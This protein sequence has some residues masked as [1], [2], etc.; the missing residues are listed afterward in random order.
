M[1][2]LTLYFGCPLEFIT[3]WLIVHSY[4]LIF[5]RLF[6]NSPNVSI[7]ASYFLQS[8][9]YSAN[10]TPTST[11]GLTT[12]STAAGNKTSIFLALDCPLVLLLFESHAQ[13]STN[14]NEVKIFAHLVGFY[15]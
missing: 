15:R 8:M 4:L 6:F 5:G 14:A 10:T 11:T 12:F 9:P 13:Y 2:I 1:L 7:E 3:W